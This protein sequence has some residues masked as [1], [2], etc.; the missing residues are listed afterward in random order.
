MET[1]QATIPGPLP[2]TYRQ[3]LMMQI[4]RC[5]RA[6]DS[7][8]VIGVSGMAKSNLFRHLLTPDARQRF[9]GA[10]W[11]SYLFL[12]VDSHSLSEVSEQAT[13]ESLLG[14]LL[15][16]CQEQELPQNII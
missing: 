15:N 6:G 11:R 5:L 13:Y 8:S 3:S 16:A 1:A 4:A 14:R 10:A 12:A 2:L 9:L 7:C